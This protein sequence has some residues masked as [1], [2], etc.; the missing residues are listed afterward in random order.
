MYGLYNPIKEANSEIKHRSNIL[1]DFTD[2]FSK[3]LH[4]EVNS[5]A[6]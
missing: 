2:D 4:Q 1:M 5:N 3:A 6:F